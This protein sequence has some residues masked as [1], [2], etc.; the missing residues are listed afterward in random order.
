MYRGL[1]SIGVIAARGGSK[2][3]PRKN[4]LE[5]GGRPMV[6]WS[7]EACKQSRHLDHFLISTDDEA[8]AA[9]AREA[10][11]SVPFIRPGSLAKDDSS[12]HDVVIHALD[13]CDADY[14][15]VVLLQATSPL[16]TGADIDRGIETCVDRNAPAAVSMTPS[17][18]TPYWHFFLDGDARLRRVIDSPCSSRRQDL[19]PTHEL[20]GAVYVARTDWYRQKRNFMAETTVGFVM[21]RERS[22]DVD[23]A[24]DLLFV[25]AIFA[26]QTET[27]GA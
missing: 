20:N 21:P 23:T 25:R 22:I 2:G 14:D 8:I 5:A 11:C 27:K 10:G 6:A 4:V 16:R 3:L 7:V 9:V 1:S 17:G 26:T 12:I 24:L 19:P 13:S 18:K 15:L